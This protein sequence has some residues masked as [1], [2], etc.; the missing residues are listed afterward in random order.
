MGYDGSLVFNTKVDKK[1]F[2]SGV[3]SIG[4]DLGRL[5]STL[6][7]VGKTLG[8][9]FGVT[10]L[11]RFSS[12]ALETASDVHEVQNVVDTAFGNMSHKMEKFAETSVETYGISKLTAK[13]M[14][15]TYMAMAKGIGVVEESAS[16][17]SIG[18]TGRL[19]DIMSFYNKTADEVQTMGK[20]ILSGESE[21]L[22]AIGVIMNQA[23]L[24]AYRLSQGITKAYTS[25]SESEKVML[26]YNYFMQQTS[27]A[28]GDFAKTSN[29]WAN[30]TRILSE[31]W[32]EF[33]GI[34][35]E[36]LM[37][38]FLPGVKVLN[39]LLSAL[40]N[41]SQKINDIFSKIGNKIKK[42]L[43]IDTTEIENT[44]SGMY[45]ISDSASDAADAISSIGD[46]VDEVSN[47]AQKDLMDIDEINRLNGNS[48]AEA[49]LGVSLD[50]EEIVNYGTALGE[51]C[52][53][54]Y[55]VDVKTNAAETGSEVKSVISGVDR[56]LREKLGDGYIEW[57]DYW[58]DVYQ[59]TKTQGL[60]S[61][62]YKVCET[63]DDYFTLLCGDSW[64]NWSD[65]W[66]NVGSLIAQGDWEE[67]TLDVCEEIDS[68]M[69][70]LLGDSWDGWSEF[71]QDVGHLIAHGDWESA[72]Y[73][74]CDK[75]DRTFV[76]FFGDAG[77]A[78]SQ[79]WQDIGMGAEQFFGDLG[80]LYEE[81][82]GWTEFWEG[83]GSY[84]FEEFNDEHVGAPKGGATVTS[85]VVKRKRGIPRYGTGNVIPANFGEF[86]TILGDNKREPEIVSPY[87]TM[88]QAFKD[89]LN[90]MGG[91]RSEIIKLVL[92]GKTLYEVMRKYGA[93]NTKATNGGA[94]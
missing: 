4:S 76:G 12:T 41:I 83:Y 77:E 21:P 7:G 42:S 73:K 69:S 90:D 49:L 8:I 61:G 82:G 50:T 9:T 72:L 53:E 6:L 52:S 57:S 71:W 37:K 79:F 85:S 5:K 31:Q 48:S 1:G 51:L 39:N 64:T 59:L 19:A 10:E 16:D 55:S 20:A 38:L 67:L 91:G 54:E 15:S 18:L 44:S 78:W 60:S 93:R 33:A 70:D 86:T 75:I 63:I 34:F 28:Q 2:S 88:V 47:K 46:A 11:I 89:A 30:Q 87:S 14:G 13:E 32:K 29:G 62:V 92:D 24:E 17:M 43:G 65:F 35:G 58:R 66:K 94:I 36:T 68:N 45:S 3:N 27:L 80:E 84:L 56:F 26:R 40:I 74:V 23:N 22:K 81:K 25:M